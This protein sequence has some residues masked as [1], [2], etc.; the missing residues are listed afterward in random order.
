L[1]QVCKLRLWEQF[2]AAVQDVDSFNRTVAEFR[3]DSSRLLAVPTT[4]PAGSSAA[5]VPSAL[6]RHR[7]KIVRT[8]STAAEALLRAVT[9][10]DSNAQESRNPADGFK[11]IWMRNEASC[12]AVVAH[13]VSLLVQEIQTV[14]QEEGDDSV[15]PVGWRRVGA[16]VKDLWEVVEEV[17]PLTGGEGDVAV[18]EHP[19]RAAV[20]AL[21]AI[22]LPDSGTGEEDDSG[23]TAGTDHRGVRRGLW[24]WLNTLPLTSQDCRTRPCRS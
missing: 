17:Y 10:A 12:G 15:G 21:A 2:T 6:A 24:L 3:A 1:L 19:V 22:D 4:G 18:E 7:S 20:G 5:A 8:A 16:A 23:S 11:D 9:C 14:Q 13:T